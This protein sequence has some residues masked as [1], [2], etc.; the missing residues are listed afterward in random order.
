[1]P[2]TCETPLR[3]TSPLQKI[4]LTSPYSAIDGGGYGQNIA[5][6]APATN[7]SSVITDT[8]YNGEIN[9]F[10]GLYGEATPDMTNFEHW[11]H[12]SQIVWKATSSVGCAV[13]DCTGQGLGNAGA[14][15]A[16]FFTVCNYKG[17][18]KFFYALSSESYAYRCFQPTSAAYTV[19]ISVSPLAMCQYN[20]TLSV[21]FKS[22]PAVCHRCLTSSLHSVPPASD[23]EMACAYFGGTRLSGVFVNMTRFEAILSL[24]SFDVLHLN[25]DCADLHHWSIYRTRLAWESKDGHLW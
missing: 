6:G 25:G 1:M 3:L 20:T 5:A 8:F 18:G 22:R 12:F 11:G 21:F 19:T 13:Q 16:P 14:D 9:W 17:G 7:I 10:D 2:T 23:R 24:L 4:V 15:V